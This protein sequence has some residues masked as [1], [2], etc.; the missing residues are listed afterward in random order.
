MI[1]R[2]RCGP[3]VAVLVSLTALGASAERGLARAQ[4]PGA[5]AGATPLETPSSGPDL[6]QLFAR[7]QA[8]EARGEVT[9]ALEAYRAMRA[10]DP[11][12]RL[13]SR[14]ERRIAWLEERDDDIPALARLLAFR[15]R[16]TRDE[17]EVAAFA[18]LA[19]E[20]PPGQVRRESLT[21]VAAEWDRLSSNAPG[22]VELAA[23][24]E[25]AYEGALREGGHSEGE[26][27][28][29]VSGHAALLARLGRGEEGLLLLD[30][31][32][33]SSGS[34]RTR[35]ELEQLDGWL[36]PL[37]WSL[38]AAL[39]TLTLWM[40]ARA[41]RGPGRAELLAPSSWAL[42][43]GALLY[44]SL[45]PYLLGIW[46]SLEAEHALSL[47]APAMLGVLAAS[48]LLGRSLATLE[49]SRT[50]RVLTVVL[51][52]LAPLAAAYLAL[53]DAGDGPLAH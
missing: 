5:D 34:L 15:G 11:T 39:L 43:A 42:P 36:R 31:E 6:A 20:M 24:A 27:Q 45:G 30:R 8:A 51:A 21:T 38:V 7:G 9:L 26:R 19:S 33:R 10:A 29:L 17:G 25:E 12:S 28:H 37:A 23:R 14:A 18:A 3:L 2:S 53:F 16:P 35:L 41:V 50:L 40:T 13:A 47:L 32:G 52:T 44:M 4:E 22:D 49:V 1:D 46:Y 48:A